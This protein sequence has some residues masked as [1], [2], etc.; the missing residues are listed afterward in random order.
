METN[1]RK[2]VSACVQ[3]GKSS[4]LLPGSL[5]GRQPASCESGEK[6]PTRQRG[7]QQLERSPGGLR[8]KR[9][10]TSTALA[11][12]FPGGLGSGELARTALTLL[13]AA[14]RV[15]QGQITALTGLPG[16]PRAGRAVRPSSNGL[17]ALCPSFPSVPPRPL[18]LAWG[19]LPPPFGIRCHRTCGGRT[20][21][22]GVQ[23]AAVECLFSKDSEIK[24]VEFTDSPESR[25]E[26]AS[27]KLFPRQHP[28]AN[29]KGEGSAGRAPGSCLRTLGCR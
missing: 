4:L 5:E 16:G 21:G 2:L 7:P 24:K 1:C 29:G 25:K 8:R 19:S 22:P 9:N 11:L 17:F 26:A 20:N 12:P 10:Q 13:K 6:A 18:T 15:A 14:R 28:G 27:S 23:P 3:L